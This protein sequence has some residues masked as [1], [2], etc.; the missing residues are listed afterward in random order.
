MIIYNVT[1]ILDESI[2]VD[3]V[4]WMKNGHLQ[5]VMNTNCFI[6]SR[7]LKVLESPND[8]VT[9]CVQY[10]AETL[11]KYRM[12]QADFAPALQAKFPAHF[13]N[14]FVV[15]RTIMEVVDWV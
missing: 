13:T 4:N 15:Y 11:E 5:E 9:Y 10:T 8:G 6:S 2:H 12:Y 1:V 14:K 7:V 3:W